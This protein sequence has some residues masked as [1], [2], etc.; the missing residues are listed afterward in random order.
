MEDLIKKIKSFYSSNKKISYEKKGINPKKDWIGILSVVFIVL[1][2][3]GIFTIYF[4]IQ[5]N[6][7]SLFK[8]N[9]EESSVT[10]L[11]NKALDRFVK[12]INDKKDVVQ[13]IKDGRM[14]MSDPSE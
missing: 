3:G 4:Y 5:I 7:S 1:V 13:S 9:Y 12:N 14:A 11:N 6:N 10:V 8:E 2:L